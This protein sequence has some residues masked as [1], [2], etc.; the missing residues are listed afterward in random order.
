MYIKDIKEEFSDSDRVAGRMRDIKWAKKHNI[1]FNSLYATDDLASINGVHI[2]FFITKETTPEQI[3]NAKADAKRKRD[4]V[5][6]SA[7]IVPDAFLE[8]SNP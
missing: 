6:F 1:C 3:K 2:M 7:L 4:V 8:E 5:G